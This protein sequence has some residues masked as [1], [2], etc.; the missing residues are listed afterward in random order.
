MFVVLHEA[1]SGKLEDASVFGPFED[2]DEATAFIEWAAGPQDADRIPCDG[3]D[4]VKELQPIRVL[5][6]FEYPE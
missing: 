6:T 4:M 2:S 1:K 5:K 3:R